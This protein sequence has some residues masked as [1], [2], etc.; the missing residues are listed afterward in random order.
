M[1]K[2]LFFFVF[3]TICL[4]ICKAQNNVEAFVVNEDGMPIVDAIAFRQTKENNRFIQ[5]VIVDSTGYFFFEN[6]DFEKETLKITG[7]GYKE[8]DITKPLL[9]KNPK[10]ILKPLNIEIEEVVIQGKSNIIQKS[11]RLIF[12]ITNEQLIKGNNTYQLLKFVPLVKSES[13]RLSVFGGR[14]VILYING[15]KSNLSQDGMALY[16]KSLSADRIANIEVITNPGVNYSV[17]NNEAIINLIL[18]RNEADG[19]KGSLSLSMNQNKKNSQ[20]GGFYMD[21]QKNKFN[22]TTNLYTYNGNYYSENTTE[23]LYFNYDRLNQLFSKNNNKYLTLG[24]NI[25][26]EYSISKDHTIGMVFDALYYKKKN[27]ETGNTFF[28]ILST[29][30]IDSIYDS[31]NKTNI[32]AKR[33]SINL[34]YRGKISEKSSLS[35]DADILTNTRDNEI[36]NDFYRTE[37]DFLTAY[38]S[39]FKQKAS[40]MLYIL[41]SKIEYQQK[42]NINQT[43]ISGIDFYYSSSKSNFFHENL[44][45][46]IYTPDLNKNNIFK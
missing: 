33:L 20:S 15:K 26:A 8:Q 39:S 40:D 21:L 4:S 37:T 19:I 6:I 27:R 18:K 11:D 43:L 5:S 1:N 10:I 35:V 32:P 41:S 29:S 7:I 3:I 34:N 38:H 22:I 46:N 17:S 13:D 42:I 44:I 2:V 45:D 12:N 14:S 25:R 36:Y 28:R 30:A 16:L 23:Y 24:G 31:Y 9:N